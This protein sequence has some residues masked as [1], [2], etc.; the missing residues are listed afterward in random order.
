MDVQAPP[1]RGTVRRP[2]HT[3]VPSRYARA[4]ALF[5][6]LIDTDTVGRMSTHP[7]PGHL[8]R[9]SYLSLRRAGTERERVA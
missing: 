8:C 1:A 3:F 9:G 4:V 2:R 7:C 6:V 5:P